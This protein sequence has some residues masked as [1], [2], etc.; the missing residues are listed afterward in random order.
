MSIFGKIKEEHQDILLMLNILEKI[1]EK[2]SNGEEIKEKHLKFLLEYGEKFIEGVHHKREEVILYP[3]LENTSNPDELQIIEIDLGEHELSKKYIRG[4]DEAVRRF[5]A[6]EKQV[7]EEVIKFGRD[8]I[9]L[10]RQ[11]AQ[12]EDE[13]IFP[14]VESKTNLSTFWG[15]TSE[16][17]GLSQEDQLTNKLNEMKKEY[18]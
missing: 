3:A 11:H 18:L 13:Q 4:L 16:K 17:I 2:L 1:L 5:F 12:R 6:G 15:Q 10:T 14:L 8:Y 7:L 9:D